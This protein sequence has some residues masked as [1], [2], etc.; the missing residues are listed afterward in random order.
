VE[1]ER[2]FDEIS[3]AHQSILALEQI[4]AAVHDLLQIVDLDYQLLQG[5]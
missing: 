2:L 4:A 1:K 3:N 5:P